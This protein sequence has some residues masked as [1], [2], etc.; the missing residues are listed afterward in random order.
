MTMEDPSVQIVFFRFAESASKEIVCARAKTISPEL[1]L[2]RLQEDAQNATWQPNGTADVLTFTVPRVEWIGVSSARQNGRK[3]VNGT[4][5]LINN[6]LK[7]IFSRDCTC[8]SVDFYNNYGVS[9]VT[10]TFFLFKF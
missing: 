9:E 7:F 6:S 4:I 3:S 10:L 1:Q 2:T 8:Y 5:G